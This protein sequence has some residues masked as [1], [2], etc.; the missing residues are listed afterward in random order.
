MERINHTDLL[1]PVLLRNGTPE[2]VHDEQIIYYCSIHQHHLDE[3]TLFQIQAGEKM[4]I[5][6]LD[7]Y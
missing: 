7:N 2:L 4:A 5:G 1:L 3:I 6:T